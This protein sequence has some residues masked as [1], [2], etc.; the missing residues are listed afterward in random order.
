MDR[1]Y[2]FAFTRV[3]DR[4]ILLQSSVNVRL[5]IDERIGLLFDEKDEFAGR[6]QQLSK[7]ARASGYPIGGVAFV[8]SSEH[9]GLQMADVLAYEVRR[10]LTETV[11]AAQPAAP[12]WQG[13]RSWARPSRAVRAASGRVSGRAHTRVRPRYARRPATQDLI[14]FSRVTRRNRLARC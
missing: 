6:A 9:P 12:G 2:L 11:R 4:M 7:E 5:G 3:L 1:P 13:L 14:S 8:D 10:Y